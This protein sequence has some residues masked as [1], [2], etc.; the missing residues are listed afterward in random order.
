MS[1]TLIPSN[2][3][4]AHP[5]LQDEMNYTYHRK[6]KNPKTG[7]IMFQCTE[8]MEECCKALVTYDPTL[9]MIASFTFQHNH[10]SNVQK[11]NSMVATCSTQTWKPNNILAKVLCDLEA[12]NGA[13]GLL[14]VVSKECL[15]GRSPWAKLKVKLSVPVKTPTCWQDLIDKGIPKAFTHLKSGGLFLR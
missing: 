2:R 10:A 15:R 9:D 1:C 13:K 7:V 12:S 14:Y 11:V 3:L 8:R 4:G 5:W 6:C